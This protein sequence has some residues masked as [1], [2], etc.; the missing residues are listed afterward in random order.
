[1]SQPG[2]ASTGERVRSCRRYRGVSLQVLADRTGLSKSFLSMVEN[3]HRRLERR[4][5]LAAVADAL[6]V[7][8]TDLT[9]QPYPPATPA[10]GGAHATVPGVRTALLA[11]SLDYTPAPTTR[12]VERLAADTVTLMTLRQNC[13]DEQVGRHLGWLLPELHA[14]LRLEDPLWIAAA[15]YSRTQALSGLGAHGQIA[16]IASR[17]AETTPRA[18]K[19]GLEVYGMLRLT[20]ALAAATTGV[21]DP[22]AA[23]AEAREVAARTGQGTAFWFM[24][25]PANTA[26]WEM[27]LILERGDPSRAVAVAATIDPRDILVDSRRA[28]YHLVLGVALAQLRGRDDDAIGALREAERLAPDRVRSNPRVRDIVV[29][30]LNRARRT[31]G[32]RDLRGMAHRIGVTP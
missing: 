6:Q 3:G 10:D 24:F 23:L 14:A 29:T 9:G 27:D 25:G 28:A 8:I 1:M 2:P 17:A 21:G 7:S 11:H 16:A 12:P 15:D 4:R 18:T 19:E 5:D 13:H 20:E 31:A 30:M 26:Q 32:G 22:D